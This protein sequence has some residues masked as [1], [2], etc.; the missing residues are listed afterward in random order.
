MI[1][2]RY[3]FEK[4]IIKSH[5]L[6]TILISTNE[7]LTTLDEKL[8]KYE[9]VLKGLKSMLFN[10]QEQKSSKE[11]NLRKKKTDFM[12]KEEELNSLNHLQENSLSEEEE[13]LMKEYYE[14]AREKEQLQL[15]IKNDTKEKERLQVEIEESEAENKLTSSTL[16]TKENELKDLEIKVSRLEVSLDNELKTLS[17]EYELTYEKAKEQYPLEIDVEEART[18]VNAYKVELRNLG[19]VNLAAIEQYQRVSERYQFL[20][21]QK[22]YL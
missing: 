19:V 17:D 3:D 9:T 11:S 2:V 16:R 22:E 8:Q 14:V 12:Q 15:E 5:D 20:C 10:Q 13:R 18:K 7:E 4:L 6:E 21:N 1:S